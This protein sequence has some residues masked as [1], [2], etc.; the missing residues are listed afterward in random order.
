MTSIMR[1]ITGTVRTLIDLLSPLIVM[2]MPS[3]WVADK[4]TTNSNSTKK[5]THS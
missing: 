2:T 1:K 5:D 3:A 4:T